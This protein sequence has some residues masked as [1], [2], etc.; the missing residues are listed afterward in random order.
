MWSVLNPKYFLKDEKRK[1]NQVLNHFIFKIERNI[2]PRDTKMDSLRLDILSRH[3]SINENDRIKLKERRLNQIYSKTNNS[4]NGPKHDFIVKYNEIYNLATV[5]AN[6]I[7]K[8]TSKFDDFFSKLEKYN[9]YYNTRPASKTSSV[10][11]LNT[12]NIF[13]DMKDESNSFIPLS[14]TD[15]YINT[16]RSSNKSK[17]S[18]VH[19]NSKYIDLNTTTRNKFYNKYNKYNEG[20]GTGQIRFNENSL[21]FDFEKLSSRDF[22]KTRASSSKTNSRNNK[23][24]GK[25][26][27]KYKNTPSKYKNEMERFSWY[28][29]SRRFED[30]SYNKSRN[31]SMN[32]K[33]NALK[34]KLDLLLVK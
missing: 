5:S 31:D 28:N 12:K 17:L 2:K 32:Y 20:G 30:F 3:S 29:Q 16:I 33:F 22:Y 26:R 14:F 6:A 13:E 18:P 19:N 4:N 10:K 24:F 27:D 21:K 25:D 34:A 8:T 1:N 7:K 9:K 23:I 15:H 11:K